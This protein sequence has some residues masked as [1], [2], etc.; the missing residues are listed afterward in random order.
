VVRLRAEGLSADEVGS[1]V[2]LTADAV[3]V[4]QH[5]ALVKLRRLVAGSANDR[6][7]FA[8]RDPARRRPSVAGLPLDH[9]GF[10]A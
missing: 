7:R 2:G 9:L 5:R 8:D 6:E 1:I 10:A 4:T 3:R